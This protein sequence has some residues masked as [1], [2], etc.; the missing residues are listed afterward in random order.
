MHKKE[1]LEGAG[2]TDLDLARALRAVERAD[3]INK[4]EIPDEVA[5]QLIKAKERVENGQPKPNKDLNASELTLS[6][7]EVISSAEVTY[8][9]CVSA[10]MDALVAQ[11]V[12]VGVTQADIV[13]AVEKA[14][15]ESQLSNNR[16]RSLEEHLKKQATALAETVQTLDLVAQL[17]ERGVDP[18]AYYASAS[19]IEQNQTLAETRSRVKKWNQS[20]QSNQSKS[21]R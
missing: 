18:N 19:R 2:L 6:P 7:E 17:K 9:N 5:W 21:T 16:G 11:A 10:M 15:F 1:L 20:N 14:A 12:D 4:E 8:N 13:S 3:L